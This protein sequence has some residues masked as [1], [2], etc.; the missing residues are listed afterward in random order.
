MRFWESSENLLGFP[1]LIE[2]SSG[3]S[4]A[5]LKNGFLI[6]EGGKTKKRMMMT[7]NG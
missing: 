3:G 7:K 2:S 6:G 1:D 5:E 4:F